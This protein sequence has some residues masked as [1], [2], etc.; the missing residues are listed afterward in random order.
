MGERQRVGMYAR[1]SD[2]KHDTAE[3]VALQVKNGTALADRNGYDVTTYVDNDL[4]AYKRHVYRPQFEAM[5]RDLDAG[6]IRGI[7]AP[8]LDRLWRQ[9][10]D[11]ERAIE[12]FERKKGLYF[13]TLQGSIDLSTSDGRMLARVMV[14]AANKSSADT[15][16]R[17]KWKHEDN[18]QQGKPAGG[19]R[20][21]GFMPD[22]VTHD[23]RE[24]EEVR[25][26]ARH[27]LEGGS[28]ND[29][30]TDFRNRGVY[31]TLGNPFRPGSFRAM[32]RNPRLKGMRARWEKPAKGQGAWVPVLDAS[33]APVKAQWE[34]ILPPHEFDALQAHLDARTAR[35]RGGQRGVTKYLLTGVG[36]CGLCGGGLRGLRG[37]NGTVSYSCMTPSMGG[38]GGVSRKAELVDAIVVEAVLAVQEAHA[39]GGRRPIESV[40]RSHD[41]ERI[42]GKIRDALLA[43]KMDQLPSAEY[44]TLRAELTAERKALEAEQAAS[45][46]AAE[47]ARA[48]VDVGMI[49]ENATLAKRRAILE[50]LLVAVVIHP[51]PVVNGRKVVKWN[52]RLIEV[53]WKDA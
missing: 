13:G 48:A 7:I 37:S 49:W 46:A 25:K 11:L 45:E 12:I 21:F 44:F 23:P 52:P 22:R 29:L 27:L 51:L 34:P 42:E 10:V 50:A 1:I 14:A 36:R 15:A 41:I 9:P 39:K 40:D 16:R 28:V 5:L 47:E 19:P 31:T 35:Y 43:W 24:A 30:V 38:C 2:D 20:P 17:V 33:G 8:D 26:A 53:V 18:Q 6:L 4:S 3:G 32:L